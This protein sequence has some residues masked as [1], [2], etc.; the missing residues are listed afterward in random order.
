[1]DLI[2]QF[3]LGDDIA[4][5]LL[6]IGLLSLLA[7]IVGAVLPRRLRRDEDS[8]GMDEGLGR[9]L[10]TQLR[11]A[12]TTAL[13]VGVPTAVLLY[14]APGSTDDRILRSALLLVGLV[15]GPL[16]AW[17]GLAVQ[18]AALGLDAERRPAMVPRLGALTVTGALGLAILPVVLTIW[19]LQTTAGPAL[20][21][22]A[23]GAALSAL[24]MR[25]GAAPV[26][27]AAASATLLVGTDEHELAAE[28]PANPGTPHLRSAR[29]VRRGGALAADLVAL[30]LAAAA[31]GVLLGVPV[32]AAEGLIVVL[33]GLGAALLT[34]AATAVMPHRGRPGHERGA[35]QLGGLIPAGLG[36]A[37]AVAAASL[38]I[39]GTYKDLRFEDV[40]LE[41]FTD[42][43]ITG[44]T[45]TPR[46]DLEPQLE[47]AVSELGTF[48]SQTDDSH[49]ASTFLDTV[50]LYS[51]T[52]NAVVA[53]ALGLGVLG[54]VAAVL[55]LG[56][57]GRLLGR[58][59][60]RTARTSRTGGSLGITAGLGATALSAAVVVAV[61]VAGALVLS[62]L[63][64]GVSSL[65]LALLAQLGLGALIVVAAFSGSL[66]APTLLDAPEAEPAQR[67][68]AAGAPTGPRAALLLAAAA[69]GL[70]ALAPVVSALQRAPRAGTVWEDR[71]LHAATPLSL[72]LLG[73]VGLGVV[74]VLLVTSCL[75]DASR[76][77]GAHAVVETRAGMVAGLERVEFAE[78]PE[79]VR[80]T[81]ITPVVI[82][83]AAPLV[84]GFGLGP[85]ALP[86]L[87]VGVVLTATG[88]G[89]W[90][91]GGASALAGAT[92]VISSGRY[93]GRGSWGHAGALGGQVLT[94]ALRS[95]LGAVALPLLLVT[96]VLTAL[97]VSAVV[98]MNT[99]G[100]SVFLRWGVA[101]IALLVA[102]VCWV[103]AATAPE[104]DL[105]DAP[106]EVAKPLF[107]RPGSDG[108]DE[109]D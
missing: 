36:G 27:T 1:M 88:L 15:M 32:L 31:V 30:V 23:A 52:P 85:A 46:E 72:T 29:M 84:A 101:V 83:V 59:V 78:Q 33:L 19:F 65:A 70:A 25:V 68:A 13:W 38:W 87:L 50:A 35:L 17:R 93:G 5:T 100:T 39:P 81:M 99:D 44:G 67:T 55:A 64:A 21:G 37:G 94:A 61:L 69:T 2:T 73:G 14:L 45:A 75:L 12:T 20:M 41:N 104:V 66:L 86:G 18:L 58:T 10:G 40:G 8:A 108:P 42:P 97:S 96:S 57:S 47:Q 63:S 62:V 105:E 71:A 109:A 80:R 43:A 56:G 53:A 74:V 76:R 77:L 103:I 22:L 34:A 28:D 92:A 90:T 7:L 24:A 91:L 3:P 82:A 51:I 102:L 16:A 6:V 54:G 79:L 9:R 4:V 95:A 107:S 11:S 106:D 49:Y 89:L 26:E 60:L 48:V 98:G